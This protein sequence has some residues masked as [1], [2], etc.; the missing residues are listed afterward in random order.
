MAVVAA[1]YKGTVIT[2]ALAALIVAYPIFM[3][4]KDIT[5]ILTAASR[6]RAVGLTSDPVSPEGL[7]AATCVGLAITGL[8]VAITQ[9][10]TSVSFGPVVKANA[11]ASQ[12]GHAISII[13]GLAVSLHGTSL[14]VASIAAGM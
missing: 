3:L 6:K 11:S 9:Y 12:T 8:T 1:L 14:R 4:M 2:G 5:A 13:T 10:Y 7:S